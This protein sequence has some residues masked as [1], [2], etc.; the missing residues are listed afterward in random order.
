ML[1]VTLITGFHYISFVSIVFPG[2]LQLWI[3]VYKNPNIEH[4]NIT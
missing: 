3:S 2:D 1:Q 4:N